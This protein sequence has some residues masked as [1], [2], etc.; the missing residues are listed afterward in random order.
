MAYPK[1]SD[2]DRKHYRAA[3][4][5]RWRD[6]NPER[7]KEIARKYRAVRGKEMSRERYLRTAYGLTTTAFSALLVGQGDACAICRTDSPNSH[8]WCVDHDHATGKV[9]GIL[10]HS[11]NSGIGALQ[12]SAT[13]IEAALSYLRRAQ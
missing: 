11:C 6:K 12:D 2:A 4:A 9:R 7:V 8:G 10:C 5:K 3:A 1:M 13:V